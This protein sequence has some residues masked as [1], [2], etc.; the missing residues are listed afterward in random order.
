MQ[1]FLFSG[2]TFGFEAVG[3]NGAS[4]CEGRGD[5]L[6]SFQDV[7]GEESIEGGEEGAIA[8]EDHVNMRVGGGSRFAD[9]RDD[10]GE[11]DSEAGK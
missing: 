5:V 4:T 9:G 6:A 3:V 2:G 7:F 10:G 11:N 1:R 8:V